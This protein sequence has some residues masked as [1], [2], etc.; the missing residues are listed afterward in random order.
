MDAREV[1]ADYVEARKGQLRYEILEVLELYMPND[2]VG[3]ATEA[4]VVLVN[5][6]IEQIVEVALGE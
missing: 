6:A 3:E 2:I 5:Q 1:F 4:V